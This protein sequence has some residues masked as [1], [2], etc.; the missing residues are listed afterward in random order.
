M[1]GGLHQAV[2]SPPKKKQKLTKNEALGARYPQQIDAL[3]SEGWEPVYTDGSCTPASGWAV[4][5]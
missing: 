3:V 1:D 5:G 2:L 4:M